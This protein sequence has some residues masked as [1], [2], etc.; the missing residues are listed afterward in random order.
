MNLQDQGF[1]LV[2]RQALKQA[3]WCLPEAGHPGD[4]DCTDMP[5]DDL[6]R[7]AAGDNLPMPNTDEPKRP[8]GRPEVPAEDR[9]QVVSIRLTEAQKA[10]LERLGGSAWLREKIDRAREKK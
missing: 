1:R 3:I 7:L 2:W 9:L 6:A 10:K 4:I 8:P 5:D